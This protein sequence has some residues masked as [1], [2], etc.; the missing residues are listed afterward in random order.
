MSYHVVSC[1]IMPYHAVSLLGVRLFRK[2][3][4]KKRER[5]PSAEAVKTTLAHEVIVGAAVKVAV[6]SG[7]ADSLG[8]KISVPLDPSGTDLPSSE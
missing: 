7:H 6:T 2:V 3:R 8:P 1:H 4:K 5:G